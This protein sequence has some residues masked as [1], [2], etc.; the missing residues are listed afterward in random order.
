MLLGSGTLAN[1]VVAGAA[2]VARRAGR[3]PEQ[4]RVRRAADRSRPPHAALVT[5]RSNSSGASAFESRARRAGGRPQSG[6]RWLWAVASETSTGMLNDLDVL[7]PSRAPRGDLALCLDCVSAIGAVPDRSRSGVHLAS[8]AS[9][10]ALAALPGPLVRVLRARRRRR[11]RRGCRA[12]STS[13]IYAD[14][15]GMPFTHSSN[16]VAALD[17][18]LTRFDTDEPFERVAALSSLAPAETPRARAADSGGRRGSYA[19][20]RHDRPP[21]HGQR[22]RARRRLAART[23]CS[24][25]IRASILTAAIGSRLG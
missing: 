15:E 7:R 25:R 5:G 24:S 11:S 9:G 22:H 19:G 10:K 4:R 14:K 2:L 18:A 13:A 23:A 12:T 8:G 6:A 20:G 17:A 1:D 16:L 21:R 3:R